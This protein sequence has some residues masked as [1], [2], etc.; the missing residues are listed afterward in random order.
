[1]NI[2]EILFTIAIVL[3][4]VVKFI[5]IV[6]YVKKKDYFRTMFIILPFLSS[7]YGVFTEDYVYCIPLLVLTLL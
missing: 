3:S 6:V 4:L 5:F 2:V 1:M 7:L